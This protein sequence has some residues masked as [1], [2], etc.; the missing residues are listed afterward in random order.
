MPPDIFGSAKQE[1]ANLTGASLVGAGANEATTRIQLIDALLFNCLGWN[2][3]D[4]TAEEH[5]EGTY[6]DYCVG[7][8]ATQFILEA[9]REG[10][11]FSL[12]PGVEGRRSVTL[13]T[14]LEDQKTSEAIR[15]VLQY[16]QAR[17]VP[18]AVLSNGH[19]IIAFFA[20]R[21]DGVPPLEGRALVFDSL[22][23]MLRDFSTLWKFLS[24]EGIRTKSL[25]RALL[26]KTPQTLSPDKLSNHIP[27]YPGFRP[28]S[29]LE[30]DLKI[31]GQLFLQDLERE[32]S[33]DDEFVRMCYCPTGA[34]SQYALVSREI[35]RARYSQVSERSPTRADP[36]ATRRGL[37]PK[38]SEAIVT[39]ALSRR[40]I[41]LLGDVGVGKS[42]FLRHLLRVEAKD[43]LANSLVLYIDFIREPALSADLSSYI[44]NRMR[45]QLLNSYGIDVQEA[46]FVRSVYNRELNRFRKSIEGELES[47]DPASYQ[48]REREML[49]RIV[50]D[51]SEH[52]RRSLEHVRGT[53]SRSPLVVLDNIDQRPPQFQEEV[54]AV[55]H[56]LAEAWPGVVFVAL[57]PSTFYSSQAHGSLA[58][59]QPRV[60]T[61]SPARTDQ[62]ILKRLN[63]ARDKAMDAGS[64]GVF[65]SGLT[66]DTADLVAYL[67]A[68]VKAFTHDNRLKELIDNPSGGN[69][70]TALMFLF[71]LTGS[72]YVL[73]SRVLEVAESG[74]TYT[75]PIH[76]VL[77][78]IIYGE[79]EHFDPRS[80]ALANVFDISTDDGREHFLLCNILAH[81]HK[82]SESASR[83][84]FVDITEVYSFAQGAGFSQEQTGAQL[85]RA[86]DKRLL[87]S[88]LGD[89]LNQVRITSVGSYMYHHMVRH[90]SYVD[91]MIVD[92]PITSVPARSE[93]TD[94]RSILDRLARASRFQQYLD[95]QWSVLGKSEVDL[96]FRWDE[97]SIALGRDIAHA[98]TRATAAV[99]RREESGLS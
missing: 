88:K 30:T 84:G 72:G 31:L 32:E 9:K 61:V 98:R 80:S 17:G 46:S 75:L 82:L 49:L 20:S 43:L 60:F 91:A 89:E 4:V 37:S 97:A 66:I 90:F 56:S 52:L 10:I 14:L 81:V 18:I 15:Q 12:P 44:A 65:P 64:T 87:E 83:D 73:T 76:E 25:Q 33:I 13:P 2:P 36:V 77:R 16:C 95:E 35:L 34:L 79:H 74:E 23:E 41:I 27:G 47:T 5:S 57:R 92:T 11:S 78:A 96:P 26:G 42:M 69:I 62:V 40:P 21:Q 99:K 71:A 58:A 28:R 29:T 19:Q 39:A 94:V 85:D 93:L 86:L 51:E 53:A 8:P 6:A 1:L 63:F 68:L 54:F 59:Y 55:A 48:R 70:R 50:E 3:S 67:D 24:K 45:E 22:H 7:K 38:L